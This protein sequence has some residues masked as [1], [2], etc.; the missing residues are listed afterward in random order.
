MAISDQ[1]LL[2]WF[3]DNPNATDAQIAQ[4]AAKDGVSAEQL[5]RVT[6]VP[7]AEIQARVAT[8]APEVKLPSQAGQ[9]YLAGDSWLSGEGN[10]ARIADQTGKQVTNFA[11]GGS[12]TSDT[13][14]QLNSFIASGGTFAPGTTVMLDIGGNDLLQGAS[15]ESVKSNLEKIVSTLG[16]SGVDVVLSG[17][18]A[19]GSVSDVTSST[20]LAMNNIFNDVAS[21]NSNVTL[22]DAMSGLLNQKNL[23]DE[24]GFHLND[25]GQAAFNASLSNAYLKSKGLN[26]IQYSAQDIRD[27]AANNNLNLD[28]ALELAPYFSVSADSV[29]SA[30]APNEIS[31][32][33]QAS[34]SQLSSVT[35][36]PVSEVVSR[37]GAT[38]TPKSLAELTSNRYKDYL[39]ANPDVKAEFEKFSAQDPGKW[40]PESYAAYH[41]TNYGLKE[42]R[43]GGDFQSSVDVLTKQILGQGTTSQWQG[44]GFGSAEKNAADMAKILAAHGITDISQFGEIK[45]TVQGDPIYSD[46]AGEDRYIIGYGPDKVITTYGNKETGQALVNTYGE[47]QTGNAWGGT[48]A[49]E[50]NTAYRVQFDAKGNPIFYTTGASSNTLAGLLENPVLNIA[51]N[52]AAAYFGGPGGVAALQ[53][54]QGKSVEDAAKA[55]ALSYAGGQLVKYLNAGVT[56]ANLLQQAADA[57]TAAGILPEYGTNAAYDA[58][59]ADLMANSPGAV[60]QMQNVVN[61]VTGVNADIAGGLTPDYGITYDQVMAD[62]MAQ[63]PGATE[64]LENIVNSQVG[65]TLGPD[66]IDVGGGW[67]PANTTDFSMDVTAPRDVVTDSAATVTPDVQADYSNEGRNYPTTGSTQGTGGSPVNAS[68]ATTTTTP[69]LNDVLNIVKTGALVAGVTGAANDAGDSSSGYEIVPVPSDWKTPTYGQTGQWPAL[70]PIDFGSRELLRG[71]QWEKYLNPS[72]PMTL[73]NVI[74]SIQTPT[75]SPIEQVRMYGNELQAAQQTPQAQQAAQAARQVTPSLTSVLNTIQQDNSITPAEVSALQVLSSPNLAGLPQEAA[76]RIAQAVSSPRSYSDVVS[77]GI[78]TPSSLAS[79][80]PEVQKAYEIYQQSMVL[81]APRSVAEAAYAAAGVNPTSPDAFFEN[82]GLPTGTPTQDALA[83][84]APMALN[85]FAATGGGAL[86]FAVDPSTVPTNYVAPN[87][88]T[89]ATKNTWSPMTTFDV[90]VNNQ[91]SNPNISDA[92]KQNLITKQAAKY[93]ID[94]TPYM[95]LLGGQTNASAVGK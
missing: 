44:E 74:S 80:S 7:V 81:G 68:T 16:K 55:A 61:D 24:T 89:L 14:N 11:V 43:T 63:S 87:V 62:L 39:N 28:Q 83:K 92:A 56:D 82:L 35:G 23:V 29:R 85:Q 93:G 41:L 30:F 20:N 69:S 78:A 60:E 45:Q 75:F 17:A 46:G 88:P 8:A 40:T 67:N 58:A 86:T 38:D 25:A 9:I 26:P 42:G 53:L 52:L 37:V 54:A 13:L 22:V 18:P 49:G 90:F 59:M 36:V 65:G 73:G 15:P 1:Q 2:Q 10:T 77:G 64:Q 34:A 95:G 84:Y 48:Y 71:T 76:S 50:G 66:N 4:V 31:S 12:T 79:M 27:F 32:S 47:R 21:K 5:S 70:T 57:D 94:P 51:A 33:G 3:L 91:I 19:V 72:Q 6:S